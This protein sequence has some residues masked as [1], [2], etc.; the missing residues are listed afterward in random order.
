MKKTAILLTICL[1]LASTTFTSCENTKLSNEEAK[2]LII[3]TLNLPA[4]FRHD[5]NK[6]PTMGSGFELDGLR[7]AGL[8]TGSEYLDVNT[9]IHIEITGKGKSSFMSEN[10]DAYM[11]KTNDVEFDQILGISINKE[12][13]T[14]VVRFTLKATNVTPVGIALSHTKAGF[15]GRNYISYSLD[16]PIPGEITLKKFDNGWQLQSNQ[17][18]SSGELLDLILNGER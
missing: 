14:A 18:K 13:K 7:D 12:E 5:I 4:R 3:T 10:G 9:P 8:I 6:R 16:S 15:S 2:N 17:N 1:I 11:F